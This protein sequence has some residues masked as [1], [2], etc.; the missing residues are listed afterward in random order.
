MKF[1]IRNWASYEAGLRRRGSLTL[2]VTDEAI[3]KWQAPPRRSPG[4]QAHYSDMA[5]ETAL[6]L[7]LTFHLP[8]RQTEGFMESIF[9]LLG[10]TVSAPDHS[11]L[12]RRATTLPSV[13]LGRMPDGPLHV[14][15]DSTGLKVYGA[16]EWLQEKH[17][18][19]ARRSWRKLHLA[20][21]AASGMIVAQTLTEKEMGD[22]SQVGPL[23]DQIQDIEQV[24]ADGAYDGA[25]TYQTVA[26][27]G[28]HIRIVIPPHMWTALHGK[29]YFCASNDL[30]GCGHMSGLS[31]RSICPLALMESD[32][33]DPYH[34]NEL[35][36][37]G[38]WRAVPDLRWRP[39]R[40]SRFVALA[41]LEP[42]NL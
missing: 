34:V 19:R 12:S 26:Q 18:A 10:V 38:A 20:V 30:V 1:K 17:G 25:P 14:L 36:A 5:I 6:M 2:W 9:A 11:T 37:R 40:S 31:M 4:G 39:C 32:Y 35:Y 8:L 28:A 3:A 33:Q 29:H 27:H 21:D 7:R 42:V 15:I 22:P 24:T 23:L 16:G 13:S 41:K